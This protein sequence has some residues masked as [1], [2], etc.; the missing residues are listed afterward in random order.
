MSSKKDTG[1]ER[2]F[3]ADPLWRYETENG[4]GILHLSL[5]PNSQDLS[6][7]QWNGNIVIVSSNTGRISYT[8]PFIDKNAVVNCSKFHPSNRLLLCSGT[9]GHVC[10]CKYQ[11]GNYMWSTHDS[12]DVT[13]SCA[14]SLNGDY[15]V[16]GG[17]EATIKVYDTET[18]KKTHSF[19]KDDESPLFHSSRIYCVINDPKDNNIFVSGGWDHRVII[20]D[21][22]QPDSVVH[23]G[24]PNICGDS[25]D[26]RSNQILTGSW[27]PKDQLELWDMKSLGLIKQSSFS[28]DDHC[29]IYSAKFA[30]SSNFILAG[31]SDA[32]Y[33]R[34]FDSDLTHRERLGYFESPVTTVAAK[35][36]GSIV[37]SAS[38]D[39]KCFAFSNESQ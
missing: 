7:S 2:R 38:Q 4:D 6:L 24:G 14:F 1:D 36:D 20:W 35:P 16:T 25:V 3:S 5:S 13:Y 22:R 37:F 34:I 27:R 19:S 15:F 23:I 21:V 39:G 8:I 9:S 10:I 28:K 17:K 11:T 31:G 29:Q 33:V 26:I 32:S 18:G 12:K 30:S